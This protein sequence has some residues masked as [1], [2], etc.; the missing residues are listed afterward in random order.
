MTP[1]PQNFSAVGKAMWHDPG[2]DIRR[3]K[4]EWR[5][6]EDLLE[7]PTGADLPQSAKPAPPIWAV[8]VPPMWNDPNIRSVPF[9]QSFRACLPTW[10]EEYRLGAIEVPDTS[11]MVIKEISYNVIAG[12]QQYDLFQLRVYN[13]LRED[14]M[15]EDMIIDPGTNDPSR[16]FIFSGQRKPFPVETRVSRTRRLI[17]FATALGVTWQDGTTNRVPGEVTNPNVWIDV[18]VSGWYAKLD[19]RHD[20]GPLVTDLGHERD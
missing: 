12:L 11:L 14:F 13:N 19:H 9:E 5:G 8:A 10:V 20:G 4:G 17:V 15:L 18:S 1:D 16:K 7:I 2:A 3:H 6:S